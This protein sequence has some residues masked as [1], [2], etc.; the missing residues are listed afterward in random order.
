MDVIILNTS[1]V[2]SAEK[3]CLTSTTSKSHHC[4]QSCHCEL[5]TP[6]QH[7]PCPFVHPCCLGHLLCV[8]SYT[9]VTETFRTLPHLADKSEC[10]L[11][12]IVYLQFSTLDAILVWNK[13]IV[14]SPGLKRVISTE[15]FNKK[16]KAT[17]LSSLVFITS[18]QCL[19]ICNSKI[20]GEPM[21]QFCAEGYVESSKECQATILTSQE[22]LL[23]K[24]PSKNYDISECKHKD[25][26]CSSS[27]VTV[28]TPQLITVETT[29]LEHSENI[30]TSTKIQ[31]RSVVLKFLGKSCQWFDL[32]HPPGLFEFF[33]NND[34]E[35]NALEWPILE[36]KLQQALNK[37]G[38]RLEIK[39]TAG[40]HM[41]RNFHLE[42]DLVIL[43][44][45][46][47]LSII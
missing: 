3:H 37:T 35:P 21:L 47:L 4:C 1:T 11:H 20:W 40:A 38:T 34:S 45:I 17:S 9:L 43:T 28:S 8:E 6:G 36:E 15:A 31:M 19:S 33:A 16:D 44:Y 25:S 7:L 14:K 26:I 23:Q 13:N 27:A 22:L 46:K 41:D 24:H 2:P 39:V 29:N 12:R 18:K 42:T 10:H 32:I 5:L 30:C